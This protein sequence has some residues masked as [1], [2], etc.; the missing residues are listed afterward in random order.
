M[1]ILGNLISGAAA[2]K[3]HLGLMVLVFIGA[4]FLIISSCS[5][6][7]NDSTNPSTPQKADLVWMQTNVTGYSEGQN[8]GV[9]VE[10][11]IANNSNI[12]AT[13][14][15]MYFVFPQNITRPARYFD[16]YSPY[17]VTTVPANSTVNASGNVFLPNGYTYRDLIR[18]YL[19][20]N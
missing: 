10:G 8:S 5:H 20:W 12:S 3:R 4:T 15:K 11:S 9:A 16:M 17:P 2:M 1:G 7:K 13:N 19:T 6:D 14:V 18:T